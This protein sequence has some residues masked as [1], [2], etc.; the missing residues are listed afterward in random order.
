MAERAKARSP[1]LA[2][3][4]NAGL[5]AVV[6]A[7]SPYAEQILLPGVAPVGGQHVEIHC[8]AS[9]SSRSVPAGPGPDGR[10]ISVTTG[11]TEALGCLGFVRMAAPLEGCDSYASETP[12]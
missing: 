2:P 4:N 1:A 7:V 11:V 10:R 8:V 6:P 9:T 3:V 12:I 5:V